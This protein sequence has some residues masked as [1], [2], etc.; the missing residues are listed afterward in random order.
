M[1]R[2]LG[3]VERGVAAAVCICLGAM[4]VLRLL[5]AWYFRNASYIR[6]YDVSDLLINYQ[7]GF[8]RRGV[9]GELLFRVFEVW[10][11]PI[12][13]FILGLDVAV[14]VVFAVIVVYVLRRRGWIPLLPLAVLTMPVFWYRRDFLMLIF[15]FV[16]FYFLFRYLTE[17]RRRF[18]FCG[19]LLSCVSVFVYEPSFFFLVPASALLLFFGSEDGSRRAG[20][21]DV[22]VG[23]V[24]PLACMCAVCLAHGG[25]TTADM[26]W[27]SWQP[28]FDMMSIEASPQ[29]AAVAF[30]KRPT[31]EVMAFHLRMNYGW[32]AENAALGFRP[33]LVTGTLLMF[34]GT[35]F[36]MVR[37]PAWKAQNG[38]R[39]A[40][41]GYLF[42]FQMA[43]L[44]P[45]FT[46]LSCDFGRTINYAIYTTYFLTYF[47]EEHG[48]SLRLPF[49]RRFSEQRWLSGGARV[50]TSLWTYLIV[51]FAMPFAAWGG[52]SLLHPLGTIYLKDCLHFLSRIGLW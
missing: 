6:S 42:L 35:Y 17:R 43:C 9:I 49:F 15:A 21:R 11:F 24:A 36:L 40:L 38:E 41:T 48:L 50:G 20:L 26:V 5:Y 16:V 39:R 14:F 51:L 32:G 8:V 18:L 29:G 7:G 46:V 2:Q 10:R 1:D 37:T 4:T 23:C 33:S 28:L 3:K 30:L 25:A 31:P 47:I 44:L 27:N 22:A 45:M 13:D 19:T 52:V 12:M 34:A